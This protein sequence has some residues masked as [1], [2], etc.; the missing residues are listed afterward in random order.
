[1][2]RGDIA[3]RRPR[4]ANSIAVLHEIVVCVQNDCFL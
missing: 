3:V 2:K 4:K 1:M